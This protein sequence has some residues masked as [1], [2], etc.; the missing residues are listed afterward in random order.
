[1]EKKKNRV[2]KEGST[3]FYAS[4]KKQVA[5]I[6]HIDPNIAGLVQRGLEEFSSLTA[7]RLLRWQIRL[8]F[9]NWVERREDP[10]LIMTT[11]GYEG[12][13]KLIGC[14]SHKAITSV[15]ALLYAQ[16]YGRFFFHDGSQGNMILLRE[17]ERHKNGEP[18][19]INLILG[20]FLL[21]N[22]THLLPKGEKRRLIPIPDLPP[23]I[24]SNNTHSGQALLQLLVMEEFS[25]QSRVLVQKGTINLP[26]EK[27]L[28]LGN[29]A[30]LPKSILQRVIEEWVRQGFLAWLGGDCYSLGEG[31]IQELCFL[32]S[33][34]D[35]REKG[36]RGGYGKIKVPQLLS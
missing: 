15:K 20:E 16:A 25:H 33:Q 8:G 22:Y 18:S 6:D 21:P 12:I 4:S 5:S 13:A 32:K 30:G 1:M 2:V 31:Y 34:G 29:E 11:G 36:K 3:I 9:E 24:G 17:V 7:H 26:F 19:R 14:S 28:E 27:W 10:R 35:Q 23:L